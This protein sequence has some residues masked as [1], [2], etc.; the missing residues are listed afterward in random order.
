[1]S[2]SSMTLDEL[3]AVLPSSTDI[4][5]MLRGLPCATEPEEEDKFIYMN[6]L[7]RE[8]EDTKAIV[9]SVTFN[10]SQFRKY[11]HEIAFPEPVT[12]KRA[13]E[14]VEAYLSQ[15]L[16]KHYY[17]RIKDDTFDEPEWDEVKEFFLCRGEALTDSL[18]LGRAT[19]DA[20][21]QLRLFTGS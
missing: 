16:T 10:I 18:F 19:I 12:E 20:N 3:M 4:G 17:E 5:A 7:N 14:A 13:I 9:R 11:T 1:M 6:C 15:P 8:Y 2:G 21:G